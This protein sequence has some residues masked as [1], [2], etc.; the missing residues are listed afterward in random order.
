[1]AGVD[2][3]SSSARVNQYERGKHV[4]AYATPQRF[5][6]IL[7][8]PTEYLYADDELTAELLLLFSAS[9]SR[10]KMNLIRRL[11]MLRP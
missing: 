1:M 6:A 10:K 11:K 7:K 5:A 9:S 8:V 2:E 4:P 3:F